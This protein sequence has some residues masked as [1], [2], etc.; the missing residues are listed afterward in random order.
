MGYIG[1]SW[2][3]KQ[4]DQVRGEDSRIVGVVMEVAEPGIVRVRWGTDNH[5]DWFSSNDLYKVNVESLKPNIKS[6]Y[7]R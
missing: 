4:G 2:A 6:H 5:S 7:I 3:L 1:S